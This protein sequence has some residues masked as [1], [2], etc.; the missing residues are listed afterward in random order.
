[1]NS[2]PRPSF[3]A[4]RMLVFDD[5]Q[6]ASHH[7]ADE[8]IQLVGAKPS[9]VLGLA[10]GSTPIAVYEELIRRYRAGDV[11]FS[12]ITTF[13]LDEYVGLSPEHPQSFAAFMRTHLFDA[14]DVPDHHTH[15]PAGVANDF[16]STAELFEKKIQTSGGIDWQLLGIGDNGH[17][18]F[19]EPGSPG[20]SGTRLVELADETIE[21]NSRFFDSP[22]DVPR[23]A[24]TMGIAT[25]LKAKRLVL[26]AFGAAKAQAIA[27]AVAGPVTPDCPASFLQRHPNATFIVDRAAAAALPTEA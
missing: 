1:M 27:D 6:Q 5:I 16:L 7:V 18:G 4:K 9:A 25:I 12:K 17:I 21:A 24:I 20:E 3:D 14:I 15:I 23:Q 11:D 19:N 13:N 8:I 2:T 10:T 26:M 22:D